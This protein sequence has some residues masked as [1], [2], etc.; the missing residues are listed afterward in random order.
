MKSICGLSLLI[1]L[2]PSVLASG[3]AHC[4]TQAVFPR[5]KLHTPLLEDCL[6]LARFILE[7]DKAHA[8]MHW[9]RA[10]GVGWEL[11]Y[12][13]DIRGRSCFITMD[14]MPGYYEDEVV[15]P[16]DEVAKTAVSIINSCQ[17]LPTMPR[18]GGRKLVGDEGK[19]IIIL[20]GKIPEKGPRPPGFRGT[21]SLFHRFNRS[22]ATS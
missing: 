7:G 6:F 5:P 16:P 19:A 4:F 17:V 2:M 12:M 18:L 14:M 3:N 11:P 20:A 8:P 15:F 22:R 13:W 9:S 21:P 1:S 10:K